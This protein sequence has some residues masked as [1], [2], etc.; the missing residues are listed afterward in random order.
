MQS[1]GGHIQYS[2]YALHTTHLPTQETYETR[3]RP[4]G[5]EDTPWTRSWQPAPVFSPGESSGQRGQVEN[6]P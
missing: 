4:L 5:Q 3:V 2:V 6:S 1:L